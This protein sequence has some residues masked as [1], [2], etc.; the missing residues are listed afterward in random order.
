MPLWQHVMV[1]QRMFD[2]FADDVDRP[3][4]SAGGQPRAAPARPRRGAG[5]DGSA[6][7]GPAAA[8]V[9][10]SAA[11]QHRRSRAPTSSSGSTATACCRRSPSSSAG[12]AATP[13]SQQCLRAGLRLT[14]PDER[15]ADPRDRRGAHCADLPDEDLDVL[16]YYEWLDGLERGIA[17]HHAGMLP[18]FKEVVEELFRAGLVKA[19][20]ATETLALGINMPARTRRAR[21]AGQVERRDPRRH[22][23]GRVHPAHR[24]RRPARHRRRGPR[25]GAVAARARPARGGRPGLHPHVSAAVVLPPVVQHGGQPGRPGRAAHRARAAGVLVRPVPGRPRGGRPVPAGAAQR[26]G[27]RRL[28]RGDDLPPRR[29]RGVRG[30]APPALRP[31]DRAVPAAVPR[32]A[33]AAAA[34]LETLKLGDVIRV[35]AGRRAGWPSSSTPG[36]GNGARR[37]PAPGGAHRRAAGQ[38]AVAGRL[39]VAGGAARPGADAEVVQPAHPAVPPR[40]GLDAARARCPTADGRDTAPARPAGGGRRRG[41]RRAA[42]AIRAHPCHGCDEREDHAR[43]AERYHRLRRET[44]AAGAPDRVPH[45]HHRPHLRPG[46]RPARAARLPGRA[47]RSP[48]TASGSPGSTASSTCWP[49]SASATG[50]GTGSRRPNS[51]PA[52][53]RWC[54]RPGRPTTPRPPR[55]PAGRVREA[56]AEMVRIWGELDPVE[57]DHGLAFQREPDLGF[58]WAAYRW[59][60]GASLDTVLARGRPAGRRLRPLDQAAD[61]PARPDAQAAAGG[62]P[63]LRRDRR[64]GGRRAPPRR[65]RVLLGRLTAVRTEAS[66]GCVGYASVGPAPGID[67]VDPDRPTPARRRRAPEP[68]GHPPPPHRPRARTPRASWT[69]TSPSP[70]SGSRTSTSRGARAATYDGAARRRALAPG[71]SKIPDVARTSLIVNLLTEDNLPSYHYEIADQLRPRR[72]LGDLGAPVDRRGGPARHRHP[73]LPDRSPARSTRSRSSGPA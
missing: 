28:P 62:D 48:P 9:G 36:L 40:P 7:A 43:W 18:T 71:D 69:G 29:L 65:R 38:A 72:R 64:Q 39:P 63:E 51:P 37:W 47:T 50:S 67:A 49:R 52:S 45:Q 41:D 26:G 10:R 31:R 59:A 61:R 12:P 55:L 15:A 3:A 34:S 70:R 66:Y 35:P 8:G 73:R 25:G 27:A 44:D 5:T 68:R 46:L 57:E 4:G 24:P 2:L 33:A 32:S 53:R 11:V 42:P 21:E 60:A 19:V 13:P 14:T 1:G 22:H 6:T 30:A 16:G 23:A 20:F 56:L 58:A 54:T 17:A